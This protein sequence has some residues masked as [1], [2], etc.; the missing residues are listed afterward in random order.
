MDDARMQ[1]APPPQPSSTVTTLRALVML[2]CLVGIPTIALRGTPYASMIREFLIQK[3]GGSVSEPDM[4][5]GLDEAPPF[6]PSMDGAA[7]TAAVLPSS[8]ASPP[9]TPMRQSAYGAPTPSALGG[10]ERRSSAP[11]FQPQAPPR[12]I[13]NT[14]PTIRGGAVAPPERQ[15]DAVL[16][17]YDRPSYAPS[18]RG[19]SS[20]N[21]EVPGHGAGNYRS[22]LSKASSIGPPS[23]AAQTVGGQKTVDQFLYIQQR[24]RDL[25]ANYY[26]LENWGDQGKCYRFHC[27]IAV[28]NSTNFTKHFEA[29]DEQPLGAMT[30]VLGDVEAWRRGSPSWETRPASPPAYSQM[31]EHVPTQPPSSHGPYGQ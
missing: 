6:I 11:R 9:A 4:R 24:L 16:A 19:A 12:Q 20:A 31:P 23:Q 25:G 27:R 3:L 13:T 22:Q 15:P 17:N 26:L 7:E 10:N 5:A 1:H 14:P 18:N 29:T 30:R 2:A 21:P 8:K 28:A